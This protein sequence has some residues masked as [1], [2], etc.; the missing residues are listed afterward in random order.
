M[1]RGVSG[2]A[3]VINQINQ[4][5]ELCHLPCNWKAIFIMAAMGIKQFRYNVEFNGNVLTLNH[6]SHPKVVS[7]FINGIYQG[8]QKGYSEFQI[9]VKGNEGAFPD[10]CAPIAGIM[11]FYRIQGID[12]EVLYEDGSDYIQNAHLDDPLSVAEN[13]HAL[14]LTSLNEIWRFHDFEDVTSLVNAFVNE[15]AQLAVCEIGVLEGLTWCLNEVMD[16]VLQHSGTS[17]GYAMGQIHPT[18]KKV[19]F[20]V[21]DYGRGIFNTLKNSSHAPRNP[22]DA[23]TMAVKEGVTR[24]TDIGQGNGLWGLHNIIRNNSGKLAITAN[25]ASYSL[26]GDTIKTYAKIP[27]L[28]LDNGA[29]IVDFQIDYSSGISIERALGG[30]TPINMRTISLETDSGTLKYSLEDRASG[31]GTRQSGK[32]IRTDLTNLYNESQTVIELDFS[33]VS[34]VSSSFADEVVGK[35]VSEYGLF[36]FNQIF[37][38]TNMNQL[39]QSIVNRSVAQR[40]YQAFVDNDSTDTDE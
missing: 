40:M 6:M 23:I 39:V 33:G 25:G 1:Q 17:Y 21:Y 19:A 2:S 24:D 15:I 29:T 35:L 26:M 7:D 38:L 13:L 16:N 14:K 4:L 12:F 28:S 18:T 31:T 8:S 5:L 30:H 36:G 22:V 9:V 3:T 34:V 11:D 37:R 20:C 10:V 32:R 27:F